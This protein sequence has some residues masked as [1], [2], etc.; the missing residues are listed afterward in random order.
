MRRLI[1]F[2]VAAATAATFGATFARLDYLYDTSTASKASSN[3]FLH[4][5]YRNRAAAMHLIS[6][7]SLASRV[8]PG[9]DT[10]TRS[11]SSRITTLTTDSISASSSKFGSTTSFPSYCPIVSDSGC[12]ATSTTHAAALVDASPSPFASASASASPGRRSRS[13]PPQ[14][15]FPRSSTSTRGTFASFSAPTTAHRAASK[16]PP[17]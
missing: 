1:V 17:S 7:L 10:H 4:P 6:V 11:P 16:M 15:S 3:A 12:D 5:G 14:T 2:R 13:P 9:L 8:P